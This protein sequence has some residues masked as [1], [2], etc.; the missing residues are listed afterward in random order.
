MR[1]IILIIFAIMIAG[2]VKAQSFDFSCRTDAD[3][4][5]EVGFYHQRFVNAVYDL[6][7]IPAFDFRSQS[8]TYTF[9]DLIAGNEDIAGEALAN[10]DNTRYAIRLQ[11]EYWDQASHYEREYIVY[12][13]LGHD[14]LNRDHTCTITTIDNRCYVDIMYT[15][16][17]S[18]GNCSSL[19]LIPDALQRMVSGLGQQVLGCHP[20]PSG[21][22]GPP[23]CIF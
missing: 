16:A 2:T 3:R 23:V 20:S 22:S 19:G 13:E 8:G 21:K 7:S 5:Y 12:H 6:R 14:L 4:L 15:G 11:R 17:C 10:C 9:V 18:G 1:T